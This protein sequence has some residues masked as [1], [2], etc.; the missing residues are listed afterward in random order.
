MNNKQKGEL[1]ELVAKNYLISKDFLILDTN[2]K[3]KSGEVDIIAEYKEDLVF[4]EV[5]SR[6]TLK[7]GY[8]SEAVNY[9]KQKK[10]LNVAKYYILVNNLAHKNVRFDVIEIYINDKKI[11]HIPNAFY[12]G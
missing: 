11:K 12:G 6:T 7:Y 3:I 5:K 8:P 10:I 1:G 4:V 2:Y 9:K